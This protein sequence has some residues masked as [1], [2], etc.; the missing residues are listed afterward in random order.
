[1]PKMNM[2]TGDPAEHGA[3]AT[4]DVNILEHGIYCS[5]HLK[6]HFQH[7]ASGKNVV[8]QG[9]GG[10]VVR[11]TGIEQ[12][13]RSPE[14]HQLQLLRSASE[15][16]LAERVRCDPTTE[17]ARRPQDGYL[18]A[19]RITTAESGQE[20]DDDMRC[21][22]NTTNDWIT[23]EFTKNTVLIIHPA[24]VRSDACALVEQEERILN[25]DTRSRVQ[26]K[27]RQIT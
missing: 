3:S 24:I 22:L 17:L 16:Q 14:G 4:S 9:V 7:L 19:N 2:A 27:T 23:H 13:E 6:K 15:G 8:L 20:D 10:D 25:Q 12:Q 18:H 11:T 1:M 26:K 5:D 21:E